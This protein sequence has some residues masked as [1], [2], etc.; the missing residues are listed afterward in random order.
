MKV[1]S[2][3]AG[4]REHFSGKGRKL[5]AHVAQVVLPRVR[6]PD[7]KCVFPCGT[8]YR[9]PLG[10]RPQHD[11]GILKPILLAAVQAVEQVQGG[12]GGTRRV[13]QGYQRPQGHRPLQH[14]R[15][16]AQGDV[17][18]GIVSFRFHPDVKRGPPAQQHGSPVFFVSR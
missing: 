10:P 7:V 13:L 17:C 2:R 4:Q 3:A 11:A 6:L 5:L 12:H 15:A 16:E 18:H 14:F 1:S 8:E 9:Q